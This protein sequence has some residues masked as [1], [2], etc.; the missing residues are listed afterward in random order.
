MNRIFKP[1]NLLHTNLSIRKINNQ[2]AVIWTQKSKQILRTKSC[3]SLPPIN[4][5]PPSSQRRKTYTH[6]PSHAHFSRIGL[7]VYVFTLW[8][9]VRTHTHTADSTDKI[10]WVMAVPAQTIKGHTQNSFA[11]SVTFRSVTRTWVHTYSGAD[12]HIHWRDRQIERRSWPPSRFGGTA[13]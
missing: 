2:K 13:L 3:F 10:W 12:A 1:K 9:I 7:F 5:L 4:G 6:T 8:W 11:L